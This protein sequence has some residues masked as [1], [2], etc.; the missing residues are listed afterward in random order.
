VLILTRLALILVIAT[1][2]LATATTTIVASTSITASPSFILIIT[3]HCVVVLSLPIILPAHSLVRCVPFAL[4]NDQIHK[5]LDSSMIFLILLVFK[6]I[7]RLPKVNLDW[8]S[9]V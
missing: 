1:S 4:I 5:L 8:S 7:L 2:T 6:I 3:H 9:I